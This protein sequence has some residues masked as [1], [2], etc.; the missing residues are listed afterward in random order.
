MKKYSKQPVISWKQNDY[1]S[2]NFL[3]KLLWKNQ[4]RPAA[5]PFELQPVFKTSFRGEPIP[6]KSIQIFID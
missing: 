5:I 3:K 4:E 2:I 1:T 6:S